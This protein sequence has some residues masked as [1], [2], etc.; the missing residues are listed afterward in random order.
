M[1]VLRSM[2]NL[3]V[4]RV[5]EGAGEAFPAAEFWKKYEAGKFGPR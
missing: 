2:K 5:T 1:D 3:K 4:V